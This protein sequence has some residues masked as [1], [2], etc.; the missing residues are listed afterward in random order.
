[1]E[2]T[3]TLRLEKE[4]SHTKVETV[5]DVAGVAVV[6][7]T[8]KYIPIEVFKDTF[9]FI[10]DLVKSKGIK[11]LVFDK[12]ALTVFHQPSMEWYFIEWKEEMFSFGLKTHRKLL[13]NDKIFVQSVKIGRRSIESKFPEGKYKEMDIQYFDSIEEA[14]EN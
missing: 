11:K 7:A 5:E 9:N 1:M 4:F 2:Q 12:R 3:L 14:V 13:P 10:G 8:D 6:T